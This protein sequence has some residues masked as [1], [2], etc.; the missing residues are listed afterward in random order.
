MAF[1][2]LVTHYV[3]HNAW[4]EDGA[5]LR[6]ATAL[7]DIPGVMV[8]GRHDFQ[9]PISNALEL[10][11]VWPQAELVIVD[12]AGHTPNEAIALELVR[13]TERFTPAAP[14]GGRNRESGQSA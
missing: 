5:L 7:A 9:A 1:A 13:A 4:I 2:R 3:R 12:S 6:G 11:R 14:G 10:S 8:N